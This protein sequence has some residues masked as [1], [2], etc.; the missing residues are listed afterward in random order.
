MHFPTTVPRSHFQNEF[1]SGVPNEFFSLNKASEEKMMP[2][3]VKMFRIKVTFLRDI[4]FY[5]IFFLI[6]EV[7][8]STFISKILRAIIVN[9]GLLKIR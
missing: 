3:M 8:F 1:L 6:W 5:A 9:K 2:R 4:R 7:V